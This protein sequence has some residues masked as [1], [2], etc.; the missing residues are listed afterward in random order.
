MILIFFIFINPL[1]SN[2]KIAIVIDAD[3]LNKVGFKSTHKTVRKD[4]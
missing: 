2:G 1:C 3:V 4:S